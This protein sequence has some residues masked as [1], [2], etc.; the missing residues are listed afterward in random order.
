MEY[1]NLVV[2]GEK[3][4]GKT[5]RPP[6]YMI[7]GKTGTAETLPRGNKEYVVSFIFYLFFGQFLGHKDIQIWQDFHQNLAHDPGREF[8]IILLRRIRSVYN[9][10]NRDFRVICRNEDEE[11]EEPESTADTETWKTFPLDPESGYLKDP[12]T[13]NLVDPE[14]GASVSGDALENLIKRY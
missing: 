12:N 9:D 11:E 7:G 5:A 14:T 2:T 10:I 13:G 6:G 8:R 3:G 4:T 1:C